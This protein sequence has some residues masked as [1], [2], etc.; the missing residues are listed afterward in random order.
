MTAHKLQVLGNTEAV[1]LTPNG[2]HSGIHIYTSPENNGVPAIP[3]VI[4]TVNQ[5][6]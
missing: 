4:L 2:D 5:I 3:S 1:R 6:S